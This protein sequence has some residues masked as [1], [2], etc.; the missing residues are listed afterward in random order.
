MA[1]DVQQLS[2]LPHWQHDAERGSITREFVLHDFAAAFDFM[3]Q[4]A[5]AAEKHNHHPEWR[6]E[7][8]V[9]SIT[10]TTHDLGGLS[11]KDIQLARICDEIY[12]HSK[13]Q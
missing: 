8:N 9:V 1:F 11:A 10:W 13:K 6:N 2:A 4:I 5:V 3:T 12:T 7:Y